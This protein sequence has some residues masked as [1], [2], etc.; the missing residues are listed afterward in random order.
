MNK[1][2][3]IDDINQIKSA[4]AR[5]VQ[6]VLAIYDLANFPDGLRKKNREIFSFKLF[7]KRV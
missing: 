5:S 2:I 6:T 4:G 7:F 1:A 3:V